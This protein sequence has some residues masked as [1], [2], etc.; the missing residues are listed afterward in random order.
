MSLKYLVALT[1][2]AMLFSANSARAQEGASKIAICNPSQVFLAMDERK[3]I[4]DRMKSEQEKTKI[5]FARRKAE[6]DE[7]K[8][9]RDELKRGSAQYNEKNRVL[10]QKAVEFRTWVQLTEAEMM[11]AEMENTRTLY[12][13]I[14]DACKEIAEARK[15]DLVLAERRPELPEDI[16]QLKPEQVRQILSQRDVLYMNK[17][18]DITEAVILVLNKKHAVGSGGAA[19]GAG[20]R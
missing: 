17:T 18:A 10:M 19:G 13:K 5:E 8:K 15:I 1:V 16:D 6:V 12:E 3:A 20:T 14:A 11:R 7:I 4:E 2:G 9:Q